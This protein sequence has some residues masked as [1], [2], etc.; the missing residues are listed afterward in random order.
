M[1]DGKRGNSVINLL[2]DRLILDLSNIVKNT[3]S[4]SI[5]KKSIREKVLSDIEIVK[6]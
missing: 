2:L 1:I 6:V 4:I 5:R 3:G